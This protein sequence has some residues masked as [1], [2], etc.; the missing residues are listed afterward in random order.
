MSVN[1]GTA[2]T[3]D[4]TTLNGPQVAP[5]HGLAKTAVRGTGL[6]TIQVVVNKLATVGSMWVV[7]LQLSPDEIGMA[8]LA[9]ALW[10]Y[11]V[12]LPPL[13]LGDVLVA[14]QRRF[15][16]AAPVVRRMAILIGL[17]AGALM[18]LLAPLIASFYSQYPASRLIALLWIL[19]LRP[20]AEALC[21]VAL[22]SL[23]RDFRYGS[24]A[25]ADGAIQLFA[26]ISTVGMALAGASVFA[27]VV[28]QVVATFAKAFAYWK[29]SR[30]APRPVQTPPAWIRRR[31]RAVIWRDT[32]LAGSAQYAHNLVILLPLVVL[33]HLSTE[34][35]TGL[36][37]FAFML[38]AQANG[39]VA[40]QLGTV[41]QPIFGRLG[42]D[43]ARQAEAFLRVLRTI[44]SV[45]VPMTFVQ[46]AVA[47]PL[48]ELLL[49]PKWAMAIPVFA[50][51]SVLEGF[52]FATAPTMSLLR[53]QRRFGA[54]FS[55]QVTHLAVATAAFSLV[56]ADHGALGVAVA[57]LICWAVSLPTAVWL[58]GR[59][60][61]QSVWKSVRTFVEPWVVGLPIGLATWWASETLALHGAW[62]SAVA[63][64]CVGPAAFVL[65]IV[66]T[67]WTSPAA[68]RDLG[69]LIGAVV[70]R[71]TRRPQGIRAAP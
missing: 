55:W 60:T 37:A 13:T 61:S 46:A 54:Y 14:H 29:V 19:A 71:V 50:V 39:L 18:V 42:Q 25:L 51:L 62:G 44:G 15:D 20:V 6:T 70:G 63:I 30:P 38:S 34:N 4:S 45:A 52:Y 58:C 40:S 64:G 36:Y 57:S 66:L 47:R 1:P 16:L 69:P 49:E 17:G 53:A 59:T 10:H 11:L 7:A 23:R 32:L 22:A 65:C 33:G 67:R 2:H 12:V 31:V 8:S 9:L 21:P 48:F 41:L 28:P 24:I 3:M 5:Q 27:M 35:Q 43:P 26:T 68:W 56:A